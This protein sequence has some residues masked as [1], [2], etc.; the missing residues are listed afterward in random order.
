VRISSVPQSRCGTSESIGLRD[1]VKHVR[2]WGLV[3]IVA[4][5]IVLPLVVGDPT[6]TSIG[7]YVLLLT[8]AA[9][10]WNLFSGFTGYISL[11]QGVYFGIG[12]YTLALF[13]QRYN[14]PGGIG[15]FLLMPLSGLI[16]SLFSIP[17]GW[18][19]LHTRR[20]AFMVMTIAIF[21]LFQFLASNL[22]GFTGGTRG[23]YLPAV[24]WSSDI[25]DLP[26]YYLAFVITLLAIFTTWWLCHSKFG[27]SLFAIRDDEMRALSLGVP[28]G[29]YKL[30]AYVLSAFFIGMVGAQTVYYTGIVYPSYA[31]NVNF[32]VSMA[33]IAFLG[34][35]G[36]VSGPVVGGLLIGSLQQYLNIQYS[37]IAAGFELV[38]FGAILLVIVV[39]LPEGIVP[40][41]SKYGKKLVALFKRKQLKNIL[42]QSFIKTTSGTS[43]VSI[44]TLASS[45]AF[46][47]SV[48]SLVPSE[49]SLN[50]VSVLGSSET[51]LESQ[52]AMA[53]S[54]SSPSSISSLVPHEIFVHNHVKEQP[55]KQVVL[56]IPH[57]LTEPTSASYR[58]KS[59]P[60]LRALSLI[61]TSQDE[62]TTK[63][64]LIVAPPVMS[65]RCP[66]CKRPFLLKAHT[67][68]CPRC[69]FTRPLN[70]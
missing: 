51:F 45:E 22:P 27:L 5:I 35:I 47:S 2:I 21:F 10:A 8:C 57:P 11:G 46:I 13:C 37:S 30:F 66:F 39:L 34:G 69:G 68:Y 14:V 56:N 20:Y 62:S 55:Y 52:S 59:N 24:Q 15:P 36:T 65:W 19:A 58:A 50:D 61:S 31:F 17:I 4:L 28:T 42:P 41:L 38:L 60:K 12:A 70:G 16:A 23:I 18:I 44:N 29:R 1:K 53:S 64:E 6:F 33:V 54:E 32:D 26:F 63:Q 9:V 7:V 25:Y 43:T 48:S 40:S 3:A 67:C 49:T